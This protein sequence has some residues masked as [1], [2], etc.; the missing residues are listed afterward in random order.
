[1]CA[2]SSRSAVELG[3]AAELS[4][5]VPVD[6]SDHKIPLS[7]WLRPADCD[8]VLRHCRV[9]VEYD[10]SYWHRSPVSLARDVRKT[11]LLTEA[12]WTVIRVRELPLCAVG[13]RSVLVKAGDVKASALGVLRHLAQM[14]VVGGPVVA[15]YA[16]APGLVNAAVAQDW[17]YQL[18][19]DSASPV[20]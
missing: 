19:A 12:G 17:L 3:L 8:I 15:A 13:D 11:R 2:V 14:G 5:F 20:P 6:Q 18:R 9:V 10:G 7:G 1:M 4:A 16:S